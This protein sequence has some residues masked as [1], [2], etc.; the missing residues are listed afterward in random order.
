MN[1][2]P[3]RIDAYLNNNY[4][5]IQKSLIGW[6]NPLFFKVGFTR[7]LTDLP[8]LGGLDDTKLISLFLGLILN[9]I[10]FILLFL[11]VLLIYSLLMINVETRVFELGVMRMIGT[12]KN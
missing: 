1:L 2:P 4:D 7:I 5:K 12:Q 9:V 10:I 8:V 11:S 6:A 3:P